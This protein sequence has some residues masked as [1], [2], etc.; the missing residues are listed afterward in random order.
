MTYYRIG[1]IVNTFGI[2]GQVKVLVDTDFAE[3]RFQPGQT[4][5]IVQENQLVDQVTVDQA[6]VHKG[7]YL[8]SFVGYHNINLVEAYKGMWLAID[9]TQQHELEEDEFYQHQII[10]LSVFDENNRLLG[11]IKDIIQLG[12]ND[13]WVVKAAK[14]KC[15]D[16]LLPYI[17]QVVKQVDLENGQVH[18]ELMEGLVDDEN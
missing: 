8:L 16:I 1:K 7:A 3:E 4:L 6:Q 10:G 5:Y 9:E 15:K 17:S 2:K 18:V 13:V 14:P 12:S 11:T